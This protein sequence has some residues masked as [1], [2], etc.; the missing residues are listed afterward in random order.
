[1]SSNEVDDGVPIAE[2]YSDNEGFEDFGSEIYR[3]KDNYM[4][5]QEYTDGKIVKRLNKKPAKSYISF[6]GAAEISF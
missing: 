4:S 3:E 2:L 6:E 5:V 1:M